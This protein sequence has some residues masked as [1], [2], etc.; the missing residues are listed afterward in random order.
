MIGIVLYTAPLAIGGVRQGLS[1]NDPSVPFLDVVGSSLVFLRAST[2]GELLMVVG[3]L[4]FLLN[5][6]GVLVRAAKTCMAAGWSAN[7]PAPEV[8]S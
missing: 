1:M 8:A 3:N 4:F 2:T 7:C 5:I 6:V